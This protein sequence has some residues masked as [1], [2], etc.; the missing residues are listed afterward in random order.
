MVLYAQKHI[1]FSINPRVNARI[2]WFVNCH[3][4]LLKL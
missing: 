2:R 3:E 4:C 1:Y